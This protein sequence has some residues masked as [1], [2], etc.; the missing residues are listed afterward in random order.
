MSGKKA[1][2]GAIFQEMEKRRVAERMEVREVRDDKWRK[3]QK[4]LKKEARR[5]LADKDRDM[6]I[7]RQ[8]HEAELRAKQLEEERLAATRFK[9]TAAE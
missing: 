4:R 1:M 3:E 2:I 7:R 5:A 6:Q 9:I 8:Q